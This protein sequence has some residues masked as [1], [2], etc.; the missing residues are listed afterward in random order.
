MTPSTKS[1]DASES[2]AL[3]TLARG[4]YAP[5]NSATDVRSPCPVINA[6]ANHGYLPRDGRNVSASELQTAMRKVV[7]L[8]L[9]LAA[10]LSNPIFL[11]H[12]PVP[13]G[14]DPKSPSLITK[15][16]AALHNPWAVF[17]DFAMRHP[18]QVD[19]TG[20]PVMDL[21]QLALHGKVE[22]DVSLTRLDIAQGDNLTSQP[23]LVK[24][25]LD[26]SSDGGKTLSIED[27]AALRK[28]RIEKQR[29]DNPSLTYTAREHKLACGESALL[30]GVFGEAKGVRVD[31]ARA[32]LED[33]RLPV[34]EGWKKKW[35]SVGILGIGKLSKKVTANT[36]A[37]AAIGPSN[38]HPL[39]RREPIYDAPDNEAVD[40]KPPLAP[41]AP[42]SAGS[43]D[44]ARL[45]SMFW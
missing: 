15:L 30:V 19:A 33:E 24:T 8:S 21:D 42:S 3:A 39:S 29:E 9:P 27:L 36:S 28:R 4:T 35:W 25:L 1:P 6:L 11:E 32:V 7:G 37:T 18:G 12:H 26:A 10:L 31:Y 20:R 14:Q 16:W 34:E 22:H 43:D 2:K 13:E 17:P 38:T 44:E 45:L 5:P 41:L 40:V 23:E